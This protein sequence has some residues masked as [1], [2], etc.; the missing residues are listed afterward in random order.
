MGELLGK[1]WHIR[2]LVMMGAAAGGDS[3]ARLQRPLLAQVQVRVWGL[4]GGEGKG[5]GKEYQGQNLIGGHRWEECQ[6]LGYS[7]RFWHKVR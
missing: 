3:G 2:G 4:Q 5:R 1:E 6:A 7:D